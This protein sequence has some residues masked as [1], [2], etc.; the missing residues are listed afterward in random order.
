MARN[1]VI[2]CDGTW[3]TPDMEADGVPCP[4][5]VFK[6]AE[7]ARAVPET[8]GPG[9]EQVVSYHAG[10]GSGGRL[11]ETIVGGATGW[12]LGRV[13]AGPLLFLAETYQPGDRIFLFGFS[14]GAYLVRSLAGLLHRVGVPSVEGLTGPS[15][16]MTRQLRA[17]KIGALIEA[18]RKGKLCESLSMYHLAPR[19]Y[20][21]GG[22]R[23]LTHAGDGPEASLIHFLG[24]WDTVGSLGVP[25]YMLG[26]NLTRLK[27]FDNTTLSRSIRHARHAVA[28]DEYRADFQTTLWQPVAG[29]DHQER[30]FPGSHGD[31]GG[32]Y[33]ETSLSDGALL[34]MVE[35][36]MAVGLHVNLALKA[37]IAP[38]PLGA[39]HRSRRGMFA[40]SH[41]TRRPA[42]NLEAAADGNT[43]VGMHPTALGR[44]RVGTLATGNP[45]APRTGPSEAS[46]RVD[47]T[48]PWGWT[49]VYVEKDQAY[50]LSAEG[51]WVDG[52]LV[53]DTRG[54][55]LSGGYQQFVGAVTTRTDW[56]LGRLQGWLRKLFKSPGFLM[57]GTLRHPTE[58][59]F[60]LMMEV[61]PRTIALSGGQPSPDAG[62]QCNP[63]AVAITA[64][65]KPG[66]PQQSWIAPDSGYLYAYPNDR[67][68][69]Y[70]NNRGSVRLY[71][72]PTPPVP[73]ATSSGP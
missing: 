35:E 46:L 37:Q 73:S 20:G 2:C 25:S 47:A 17:D 69:G 71:I 11:I 10:V 58:R 32:G 53:Y 61:L 29:F 51:S 19:P 65:G 22:P 26:A 62:A 13:M 45:W 23:P 44:Y 60:Q 1:L 27:R 43:G 66:G 6:L 70:R 38:N 56:V 3:N 16:A 24:A 14:R 7:L 54:E 34:W 5:N 55:R 12:G 48:H 21:A 41:P 33:R 18:Y 4:T 40:L 50:T 31:V 57:P 15:E 28:M 8:V 59:R 67:W 64:V 52:R 72:T 30:W 36:A 9:A 49:G 39:A 63:L 68:R 42:G